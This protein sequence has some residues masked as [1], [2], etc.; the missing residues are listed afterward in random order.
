MS[1]FQVLE[2]PRTNPYFEQ[3]FVVF[4]E[5]RKKSLKISSLFLHHFTINLNFTA[6]SCNRCC[7]RLI[8]LRI[9]T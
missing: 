4:D 8:K 5:P 9:S 3:Y 2:L 6:Q 7:R 1:R